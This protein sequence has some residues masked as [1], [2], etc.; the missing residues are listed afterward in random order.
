MTMKQTSER[1]LALCLILVITTASSSLAQSPENVAVVINER[2]AESKHVGTYYAR[3]RG[4]PESNVLRIEA[5]ND[6]VISREQYLNSIEG[7]VGS[8]I[9]RAGL[10]DRLLY[11]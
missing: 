2:S 9:K 6:E 8:A 3:T 4:L 5:P 10:Q 11:I 7:P 1:V